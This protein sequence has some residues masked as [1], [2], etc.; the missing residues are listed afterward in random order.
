MREWLG[1]VNNRPYFVKC[2]FIKG[3]RSI[4]HVIY[5]T[6]MVLVVEGVNIL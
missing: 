3:G 6:T 5:I 4:C 2:E 1:A